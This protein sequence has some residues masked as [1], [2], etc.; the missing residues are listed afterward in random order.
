MIHAFRKPVAARGAYATVT[1]SRH[2]SAQGL[3]LDRHLDGSV[4]IETG[5]G[6]V[7]GL[8]LSGPAQERPGRRIWLPLFAG[9]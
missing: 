3:I 9:M 4:T 7:T 1:I 6:T 2:Q 8:P 5:C